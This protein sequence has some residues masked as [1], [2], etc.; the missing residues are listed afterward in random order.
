[1]SAAD[2][3][4]SCHADHNRG[5]PAIIPD[6][7]RRSRT[8]R[9][10]RTV[11]CSRHPPVAQQG[12]RSGQPSALRVTPRRVG[13]SLHAI[14]RT[15]FASPILA[16]P[17][18]A[19]P[20]PRFAFM[21]VTYF[22]AM[23]EKSVTIMK[24][25]AAYALRGRKVFLSELTSLTRRNSV[26]VMTGRRPSPSCAMCSAARRRSFRA[27]DRRSAPHCRRYHRGVTHMRRRAAMGLLHR[28]PSMKDPVQSAAEPRDSLPITIDRADPANLKVNGTRSRPRRTSSG[29]A[30][31]VP[32]T[33]SS[34]APCQ[35]LAIPPS[36][37]RVWPGWTR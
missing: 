25:R 7:D 28:H 37:P 22:S 2:K 11:R 27:G 35:G 33:R 5:P 18:P 23:P 8:V 26:V 30:G 4:H 15:R 32:A 14:R 29:T 3:S 21:I 9:R 6:R 20:V 34:A 10:G 19:V 36:P 17:A 13:A 16:W 12:Q 24:V 1:M 31:T